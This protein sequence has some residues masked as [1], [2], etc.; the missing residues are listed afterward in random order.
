MLFIMFQQR[1]ETSDNKE[2]ANLLF[3]LLLFAFPKRN[4]PT[5]IA[6]SKQTVNNVYNQRLKAVLPSTATTT[7]V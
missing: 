6:S 3:I 5:Y 7:Y 4:E 1:S 2:K